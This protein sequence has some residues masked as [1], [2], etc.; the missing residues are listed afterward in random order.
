[1]TS[2]KGWPAVGAAGSPTSEKNV[3]R[4]TATRACVSGQDPQSLRGFLREEILRLDQQI[5]RLIQRANPFP[6]ETHYLIL[7]AVRVYAAKRLLQ[8]T[9][10]PRASRRSSA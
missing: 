2:V 6:T 1:M 8:G 3:F 7:A 10:R 5:D 4:A 9:L